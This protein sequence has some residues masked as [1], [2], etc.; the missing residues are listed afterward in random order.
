MT[1]TFISNTSDFHIIVLDRYTIPN[2]W[3]P[4]IA[5]MCLH[6][7][8]KMAQ[9]WPTKPAWQVNKSCHIWNYSLCRGHLLPPLPPQSL[10]TAP[11][12]S[13]LLLMRSPYLLSPSEWQSQ[14]LIKCENQREWC[15][16]GTFL[17]K[18]KEEQW[19]SMIIQQLDFNRGWVNGGWR[20]G[21]I[22]LDDRHS[23]KPINSTRN[24]PTLAHER[25]YPWAT[26]TSAS[27][28]RLNQADSERRLTT[29]RPAL[30]V[31]VFNWSNCPKCDMPWNKGNF[32]ATCVVAVSY[33]LLPL[34]RRGTL[35]YLN[36][37]LARLLL[38]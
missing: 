28:Q 27:R 18:K 12:C 7:L 34:M 36:T 1:H 3:E 38:F 11:T 24:V 32:T 6:S 14:K 26:R 2:Q 17:I 10:S 37:V 30:Q 29:T 16:D 25:P 35:I 22:K 15:W 23:G 4:Q 13:R 19:H 9:K 8:T 33:N 21:F 20:G 5:V 31:N